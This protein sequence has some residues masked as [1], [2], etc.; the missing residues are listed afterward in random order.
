MQFPGAGNNVLS[1]ACMCEVY[2]VCLTLYTHRT[3]RSRLS[4]PPRVNLKVS[5]NAFAA[6]GLG[7]IV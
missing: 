3:V 4:I 1:Y 7:G 2:E 6:V 5:K